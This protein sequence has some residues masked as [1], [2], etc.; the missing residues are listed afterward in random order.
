MA[1]TNDVDRW[2]EVVQKCNYLPEVRGQSTPFLSSPVASTSSFEPTV[3]PLPHRPPL[4]QNGIIPLLVIDI[5]RPP[6]VR[7][8]RACASWMLGSGFPSQNKILPPDDR[9]CAR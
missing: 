3:P 9:L 4:H 5:V 6:P 1:A 8:A 2:I 7:A